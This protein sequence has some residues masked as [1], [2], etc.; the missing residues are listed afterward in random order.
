M[1][2][3]KYYSRGG[4]IMTLAISRRTRPW[5]VHP[6]DVF[7]DR[8]WPEW[9]REVGEEWNP[10]VDFYEKDGKY[11]LTAEVPGLH[12]DDI[13][14]SFENGCLTIG[15]KKVSG[16][17]EEGTDYY[18]RETSHGSFCRT[19]NLPVE[20]DEENVEATYKDG[21][22]TLVMLVKEVSKRKKI[23]VH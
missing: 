14:I 7:F 2:I 8:V 22:L 11:Y 23:E 12:K 10:N 3:N 6:G 15:G 19:F 16:K 9:R 5:V 18:M 17:D 20:V 13:S 4:V 1:N 21:V